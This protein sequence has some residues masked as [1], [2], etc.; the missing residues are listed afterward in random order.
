M[1]MKLLKR[2]WDFFTQKRKMKRLALPMNRAERRRYQKTLQR[3]YMRNIIRDKKGKIPSRKDRRKLAKEQAESHVNRMHRDRLSINP[4]KFSLAVLLFDWAY[5]I[6]LMQ[7]K[8]R[9]QF[10]QKL[11]TLQLQPAMKGT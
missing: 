4:P 1:L 5:K 6:R 11:N 7:I 8:W 10:A 9:Q 2:I 3:V